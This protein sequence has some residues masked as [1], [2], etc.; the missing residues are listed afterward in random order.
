MKNVSTCVNIGWCRCCK[1]STQRCHF[2]GS[3][4]AGHCILTTAMLLV[5]PTMS[6][7]LET[8][9][10]GAAHSEHNSHDQP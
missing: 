3:V 6:T 7:V 9:D 2:R 5:V 8:R 10:G 4:R 1:L